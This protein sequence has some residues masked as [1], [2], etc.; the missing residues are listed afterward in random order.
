MSVTIYRAIIARLLT[1][2][3]LL[4]TADCPLVHVVWRV[5]IITIIDTLRYWRTRHQQK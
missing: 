4:A 2:T 5:S 1:L 3:K